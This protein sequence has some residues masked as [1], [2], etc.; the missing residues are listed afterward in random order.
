MHGEVA[1]AFVLNLVL[2]FQAM[3]T[4]EVDAF[5]D[6]FVNL[7]TNSSAL[8][9]RCG[10]FFNV[11]AF[12]TVADEATWQRSPGEQTA[13]WARLPGKQARLLATTKGWSNTAASWKLATDRFKA[14]DAARRKA[15]RN[16]TLALYGDPD[17]A[18]SSEGLADRL[19]TT[20]QG[21]GGRVRA[22][23]RNALRQRE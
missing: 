8:V 5:R 23:A 1:E 19:A 14:F 20:P 11:A 7:A 2:R 10:L 18:T 9:E 21:L 3:T 17:D 6:D 13:E 4:A 22:A 16:P 12:A 15:F